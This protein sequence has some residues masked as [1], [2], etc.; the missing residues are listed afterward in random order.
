[1]AIASAH[2]LYTS[3]NIAIWSQQPVAANDLRGFHDAVQKWFHGYKVY[4]FHSHDTYPPASY[5]LLWPFLGWIEVKWARWLWTIS[6]LGALAFLSLMLVRKSCAADRCEQLLIWLLPLSTYTVGSAIVQGQLTIHVLAALLA[7]ILLVDSR[8]RRLSKDILASLLFV[9]ALMKPT[10]SIPFFW[11]ILF[12]PGGLRTALLTVL[13]YTLLTVF[14]GQFQQE[15]TTTLFFQFVARGLQRS[16]GASLG[17]G[18]GAIHD[19]LA[20]LG[21]TAFFPVASLLILGALGCWVYFNRMGDLWI[22]I[23]TAGIVARIW[24]Y[25]GLYDDPLIL[26]PF[27]T[28]FRIAKR[29]SAS[30]RCRVTA[31][32]LMILT[33]A[34]LETP[35]HL[36]R[37]FPLPLEELFKIFLPILW[38]SLLIFILFQS[39]Q[40]GQ[41]CPC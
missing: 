10:V 40:D 28:L 13:N 14:A 33:W 39:R 8:N 20:P 22:L 18:Y 9:L 34:A 1:M 11:I 24:S 27:I 6:A 32:V 5:T 31:G 16:V 35:I 37:A 4:G 25:H 3:F 30:D 21:N 29:T 17:H 7:G 15:G 2:R 38:T 36:L 19:L 12:I 41:E 26:L 23:G